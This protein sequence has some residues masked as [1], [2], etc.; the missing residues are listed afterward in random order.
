MNRYKLLPLRRLFSSHKQDQ[1][2][3][4]L[5]PQNKLEILKQEEEKYLNP[6][7]ASGKLKLTWANITEK[8][9]K[10]IVPTFD[11]LTV[12]DFALH[13]FLHIDFHLNSPFLWTPL[14]QLT[15]PSE[16]LLES[17]ED[18]KEEFKEVMRNKRLRS[19]RDVISFHFTE[20][21]SIVK[22]MVE[23]VV[24]GT[25]FDYLE[26]YYCSPSKG[27]KMHG[28]VDFVLYDRENEEINY[29][30]PVC[31]VYVMK[32]EKNHGMRK[33]VFNDSACPVGGIAQWYIQRLRD[34]MEH[35]KEFAERVKK[36]ERLA[37]IRVVMTN[38]HIW[39]LYEVDIDYRVRATNFY[40]PRSVGEIL[41]DVEGPIFEEFEDQ[42]ERKIWN[43]FR[44]MQIGLGVL[45]FGM[46]TPNEGE[47]KLKETYDYLIDLQFSD[48]MSVEDKS[49]VRRREKVSKYLPKFIRNWYI[50]H[51]EKLTNNSSD[52]NKNE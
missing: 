23:D 44:Q 27:S 29:G 47:S 24:P 52:P 38:G 25:G 42:K 36:D 37:N 40:V 1:S 50:G 46:N 31:P 17:M 51:R 14:I 41:K 20:S 19:D 39:R 30:F 7:S 10:G 26:D 49:E 12:G 15:D 48:Q 34:F 22:R 16:E 4:E 45:R 35:D 2:A 6:V 18:M 5:V 13:S 43:D 32:P 3:P 11:Q 33:I 9:Y 8:T 28:K 21:R